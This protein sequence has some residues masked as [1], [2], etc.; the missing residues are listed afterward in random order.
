M[1]RRPPAPSRRRPGCRARGN[2]A[3]QPR[4]RRRR[5]GTGW[6]RSWGSRFCAEAIRSNDRTRVRQWCPCDNG[7]SVG[8]VVLNERRQQYEGVRP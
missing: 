1:S 3:R 6:M 4:S 7:S 8:G 5:Y 2:G